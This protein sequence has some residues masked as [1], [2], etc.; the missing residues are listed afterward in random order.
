MSAD[1][2]FADGNVYLIAHPSPLIVSGGTQ[3]IVVYRSVL[4]DTVRQIAKRIGKGPDAHGVTVAQDKF[5]Y[6]DGQGILVQPGRTNSAGVPYW[7]EAEA[8]GL[9]YAWQQFVNEQPA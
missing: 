6:A 1:V 7:T 3:G 4:E 8:R 2:S 5:A 9:V